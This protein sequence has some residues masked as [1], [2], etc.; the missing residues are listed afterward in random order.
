MRTLCLDAGGVLVL[1]D[2][3]LVTSALAQVG[4]RIDPSAVAPA[5]Y[6]AVGALDAGDGRGGYLAS[7]SRTLR[8]PA[9]CHADA[10]RA[11]SRLADR[12]QS[13]QILWSEPVPD[14]LATIAIAR[15]A[16]IAVVVVTNSDGHAAQN[17]RDA[18]ICQTTRGAGETVDAI[19]DSTRVGS[20]KPDPEI[21]RLALESIG[22][23]ADAAVHVGDTLSTDI[24]GAQA[25]GIAAIHLD[26]A[27]AC[28]AADHRHIRGLREL[29]PHLAPVGV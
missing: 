27:C 13:G 15:R 21:F 7:L 5:H 29:W 8:V 16:G 9:G 22:A 25:A 28:G 20:A 3:D 23:T 19:V 12:A 10:V 18:G 1:P 11:L 17:L 14:A 6:R 24:V 4:V 26:P 2:R